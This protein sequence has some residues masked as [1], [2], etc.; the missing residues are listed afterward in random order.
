MALDFLQD[1]QV[2]NISLARRISFLESKGMTKQEIDLTLLRLTDPLNKDS[3]LNAKNGKI[4]TN[5]H[6]TGW[7]G[8]VL[9]DA[10]IFCFAYLIISNYDL[11]AVYMIFITHIFMFFYILF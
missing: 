8:I 9:T 4:S 2:Q 11:F 6:T 7:R 3:N 10:F 1:P 5:S